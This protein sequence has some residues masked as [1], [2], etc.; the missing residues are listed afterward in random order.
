MDNGFKSTNHRDGCNI[1]KV[2]EPVPVASENLEYSPSEEFYNTTHK[3]RGVALVFNHENFSK[4]SWRE[5]TNKDRDDIVQVLKD[6]KFSVFVHN[7]LKKAEVLETLEKWSKKDHTDCDCLM[8]VIMTH[9]DKEL[10][11]SDVSYPVDSLWANFVGNKCPSLVGKPKIF[12]IQACRGTAVDDGVKYKRTHG[13]VRLSD[14]M[15]GRNFKELNSSPPMADLLMMY[16]TYEGFYS[17]RNK[18]KGSWFIQSLCKELSE[19]ASERDLLTLLTDV[20]RRIAY[21][22]QSSHKEEKFDNK[23]Q[24]PCVVS[25]LTKVFYFTEKTEC[26]LFEE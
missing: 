20:S 17:F 14:Q 9:G 23:K 4:E 2:S 7:D 22:Y 3:Y 13:R 15:D 6:L 1:S 5:G 26:K 18:E 11:A 12:F 10:C 21:E 24:M 25:K 8:I 16:S 19:E